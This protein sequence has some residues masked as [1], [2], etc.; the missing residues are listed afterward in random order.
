MEE[1]GYLLLENGVVFEGVQVGDFQDIDGEVVF[2]TSMTGYQ[3]I[4]TDP[5]YADQVLVFCYPL[6][7]NYG[8]N[9]I[10]G[11]SNMHAL[12][13]AVFGEACDLPSHYQSQNSLVSYMKKHHISGLAGVDTRALVKLIRKEGTMRGRMVASLQEKASDYMPDQK[14][15]PTVEKVSVKKAIHYEGSGPHIVVVDYGYKKSIRTSLQQEGCKVTVV[16]YSF[17]F[18]QIASLKPD[19]V[20]FSNG[21]G[22]PEELASFY[23]V[24]KQLTETYPSLGICLGHQLIALAHGATTTKLLYGHRGG[25]HPVKDLVTNKIYMTSQNHGYEVMHHS[26]IRTP[27]M[28]THENVNDRTVEGIIHTSLPVCGVQFHP[29]A[30]A[31]PSDTSF[32]IESFIS[33]VKENAYASS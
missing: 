21:P 23:P 2:N 20:L 3:E 31:G 17:T 32:M 10:D 14:N 13:G 16:P 27:F 25:N 28:V 15:G 12:S 18:E 4:L 29:E 19:G 33:T 6:I 7:G 11:E 8:I 9:D 24:I 5:S 1:K 26:L 22:N 30:H